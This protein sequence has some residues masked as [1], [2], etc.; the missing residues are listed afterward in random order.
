[1]R[2]SRT[3]EQRSVRKLCQTQWA[4][5]SAC[6]NFLCCGTVVG[7][8]LW[9][10]LLF[11][12]SMAC[13]VP[14]MADAGLLLLCRCNAR[15]YLFTLHM[16]HC[17]CPYNGNVALAAH[18]GTRNTVSK[19]QDHACCR[20]LLA[21]MWACRVSAATAVLRSGCLSDGIFREVRPLLRTTS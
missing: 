16:V 18:G 20:P 10:L 9:L 19:T 1:M 14:F 12:C 21:C 8:L 4:A 3:C 17:D 11:D 15:T 5:G 7:L 6:V 2:E 13:L